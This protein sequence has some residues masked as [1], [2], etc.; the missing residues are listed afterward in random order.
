MR[1]AGGDASRRWSRCSGA[2][3]LS[4]PVAA[5][6]DHTPTPSVVALVGSLQSEL[7]C[8]GRLAARVPAVPADAGRGVAR[9]LAGHVRRPRR[10]LRLQGRPEQRL[11]RE[12]RRGR[13]TRRR[14][15]P[16]SRSRWPGDLHL[17]PQHPSDQ[18]RRPSCARRPGRRALAREAA[19]SPGISATT[20]RSCTYRLYTAP[21]GGMTVTDGQVVGGTALP[22]SPT[23]TGCRGRCAASSRTWR[24]STRS[25]CPALLDPH[26]GRAAQGAAGR[27]GVRRRRR[28]GRRHRGADPGGHRPG[29]RGCAAQR[30]R[31]DLA[32]RGPDVGPVGAHRAQRHGARLRRPG[33]ATPLPCAARPLRRAAT[34]VWTVTGDRTWQGRYYLF[35]VEVYVPETDRVEHNRVTDPYSV[36]LSTNSERSLLVDLD[37]RELEPAGWDALQQA[38]AGQ[39]EDQSIYELHV[40]DFSINDATVPAAVPR[41]VRRL[42]GQLEQRHEAPARAGRGGPDHGA[43]AAGQRHRHDRGAPRPAADPGCDLELVPAGQRAAA[44]VRAGRRRAGRLQLGLRP[45]ALHHPGRVVRHRPGGRRAHPG[46]PPHGRGA[47]RGRAARGD[48]RG[49]QPHHRRR[50]GRPQHPGPGRAGLLPPAQPAAPA[51]SRP[52]RAARTPRPSTR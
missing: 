41:H 13:G 12:L 47:E 14:R 31:P 45:A 29:V 52:P 37:S 32:P 40:R 50:A 26:G 21:D 48:R 10:H 9:P 18:R 1:G 3:L 36:G 6:A 42:H 5:V 25:A 22:L 35:E 8:P 34:G 4:Q 33:V 51:R 20:P 39:P 17:R 11:G 30:P 43:P 28:A 7:G 38:A 15:H 27:G 49:L 24:P 44:G 16:P 2:A 19:S 23:P 46:V